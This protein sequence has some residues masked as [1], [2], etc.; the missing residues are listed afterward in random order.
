[1][2]KLTS[3]EAKAHAKMIDPSARFVTLHFAA[4]GWEFYGET[5]GQIDIGHFLD[6][7]FTVAVERGRFATEV[8]K[9]RQVAAVRAGALRSA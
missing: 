3:T 7:Q 2:T 9:V 8:P 1:M 4:Q 5:A 6:G